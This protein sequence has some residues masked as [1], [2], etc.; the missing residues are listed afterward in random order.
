MDGVVR[1]GRAVS[2]NTR[3]YVPR[4]RAVIPNG[5]DLNQFYPSEQ[6]S[7]RPTVLF[8]GT[9]RGRKRGQYLVRTFQERVLPVLPK[10]SL[11]AVCEEP[12][13]GEGVHWFGKIPTEV[14]SE[15]YRRAWVF[16]L[17]SSYEGFGVPYI[18]AMASGTAV[19]ATP[20][21][22]AVEV[23]RHGTCG[24][25]VPLHRLG[26]AL[27]Q[28]LRNPALRR[29]LETAGLRCSKAYGWDEVCAR[30]E[31]LYAGGEAYALNSRVES[32]AK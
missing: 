15:L 28:V 2:D 4:V 8:V 31:M 12:V 32:K 30:Y 3:G 7:E 18:E 29:Y 6:K 1:R 24:L 22:G 10:A 16:C 27:L 21:R 26:S 5:V 11:W 9:M 13:K 20:N 19:I 14:L 17:P 23:L 25:V